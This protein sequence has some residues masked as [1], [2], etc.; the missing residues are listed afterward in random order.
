MGVCCDASVTWASHRVPPAVCRGHALPGALGA[1]LGLRVPS[2][3]RGPGLTADPAFCRSAPHSSPPGAVQGLAPGLSARRAGRA[4]GPLHTSLFLLDDAVSSSTSESSALS[5]KRF[6]L[7]G[8]ANLKGQ[9]GKEAPL[10]EVHLPPCVP[11]VAS[12]LH[13]VVAICGDPLRR[14]RPFIPCTAHPKLFHGVVLAHRP[15]VSIPA[16][17]VIFQGVLLKM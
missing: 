17:E 8:F 5:R 13:G 12:V 1:V 3:C 7:Q 6:T 15:R 16:P 2:P 10:P 11:V 14:P 9:R 4:A